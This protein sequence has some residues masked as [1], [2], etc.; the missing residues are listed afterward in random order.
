MSAVQD[1]KDAIAAGDTFRVDKIGG[2]RALIARIWKRLK[3]CGSDPYSQ[4][5][6]LLRDL[7]HAINGLVEN[8]H[9][10][11]QLERILNDLRETD[12]RTMARISEVFYD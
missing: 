11:D 9:K 4:D 5:M 12:G 2:D 1:W 8:T 6:L 3:E 10:L 7:E